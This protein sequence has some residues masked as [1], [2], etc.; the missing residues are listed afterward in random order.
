M[1]WDHPFS[2]RNMTAERTVQVGFRGD[3]EA[4]TFE[5]GGIDNVGGLL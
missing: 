2:L 3:R 1:W 4:A 5:K